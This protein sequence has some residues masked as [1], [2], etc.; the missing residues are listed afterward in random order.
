M[1]LD[2]ITK[3]VSHVIAP[4]SVFGAEHLANLSTPVIFAAN[5]VSHMDTPVLLTTLPA[6][7]RHKTIVAAASDYFFDRTWKAI[8][9][10]FFLAAI[11]IERTKVNRASADAAAQ[12]IDEGW[13]LVIFPEGGR[14]EDGWAQPFKG[15][16]AYL[17]KRCNI[18]VI[19]CYLEG[20]RGL[21][22]KEAITTTEPITKDVSHMLRRHRI[23][24]TFGEPVQLRKTEDARRFGARIE[25]AVGALAAER[26][27][28]YWTALRLT[29]APANE[30]EIDPVVDVLQGT[31]LSGWRKSWALKDERRA[32][33]TGTDAPLWP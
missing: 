8:M 1:V 16:A 24:V 21:L 3:P 5:H 19:P 17:A 29:H 11:P 25:R 32:R 33:P 18:P 26:S 10:S 14:S 2:N 9:W 13:N 15:G 7:L 22:P 23:S 4:R 28:D 30:H 20:T 31:S 12:L 27:A 6:T